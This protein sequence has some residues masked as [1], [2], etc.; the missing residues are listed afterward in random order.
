MNML[1]TEIFMMLCKC[2]YHCRRESNFTCL[3]GTCLWK[4][5]S[6]GIM[7]GGIGFNTYVSLG[8]P[9]Q[10]PVQNEYVNVL[11][12]FKKERGGL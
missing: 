8:D 12:E 10:V 2:F 9:D 4:V 3:Q 5:T 6:E 7:L 11:S 1:V